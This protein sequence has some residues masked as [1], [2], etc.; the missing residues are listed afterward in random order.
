MQT[1][2]AVDLFGARIIKYFP[3]EPKHPINDEYAYCTKSEMGF[4]KNGKIIGWEKLDKSFILDMEVMP[5][6][7]I[8]ITE[9]G[10]IAFLP[11]I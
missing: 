9:G 1:V 7:S 5:L 6:G 11:R 3:A 10:K 8:F 4:F 2:M